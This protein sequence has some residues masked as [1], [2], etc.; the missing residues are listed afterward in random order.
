MLLGKPWIERNQARRQEEEAI[1]EQQK[2]EFK[3]IMTK[4]IAHLIEEHKNRSKLFNTRDLDVE[5][6]RTLKDP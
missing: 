3:K 5:L 2:Q 6:A 4:R 1:L